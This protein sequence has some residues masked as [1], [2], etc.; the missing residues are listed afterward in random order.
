MEKEG[1]KGIELREGRKRCDNNCSVVL[2]VP[3]D[4]LSVVLVLS[5]VSPFHFS[6]CLLHCYQPRET[7]W[8]GRITSTDTFESRALIG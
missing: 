1:L 5:F 7:D 3:F 2:L 8:Y 6:L 4:G